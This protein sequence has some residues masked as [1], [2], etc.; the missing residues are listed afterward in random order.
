MTRA[1]YLLANGQVVAALRMN[2][3]GVLLMPILVVTVF[4][5]LLAWCR[6][7]PLPNW[8]LPSGCLGLCWG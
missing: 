2:I 8:R 1:S 5:G 7:R 6:G 4:C 3:L